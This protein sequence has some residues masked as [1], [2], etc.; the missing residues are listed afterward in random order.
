M[1][2]KCKKINKTVNRI[3]YR[4]FYM[5]CYENWYK[6]IACVYVNVQELIK[7]VQN[8]VKK[9]NKIGKYIANTLKIG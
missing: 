7:N 9:V 4:K 3:N 1:L 5:S 6:N 2:N 8:L